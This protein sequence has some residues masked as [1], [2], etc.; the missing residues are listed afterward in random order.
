MTAST[1]APA[2]PRI[3]GYLFGLVS[4]YG[5]WILEPRWL[6][7]ALGLL[8]LYW[9]VNSPDRAAALFADADRS[10][11]GLIAPSPIGAAGRRVAQ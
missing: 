11:R 4:L 3:V 9:L 5:I 10:L 2:S 6:S 8:I 1:S 7:G